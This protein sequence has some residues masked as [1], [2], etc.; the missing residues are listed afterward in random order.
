MGYVE[1]RQINEQRSR[2]A[3]DSALAKNTDL[4]K[5]LSNLDQASYASGLQSIVNEL[6]KVAA[7]TNLLSNCFVPYKIAS[8]KWQPLSHKRFEIKSK[9]W[10]PDG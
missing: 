2:Q 9:V 10:R 1:E 3:L 4:G 8:E 5:R 6:N 7:G